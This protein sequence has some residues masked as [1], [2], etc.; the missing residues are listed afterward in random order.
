[1][2]EALLWKDLKTED[3]QVQC[4]LCSQYCRIKDREKGFCGVRENRGGKLYTL[5]ADRAAAINVDPVE[6]KPLY[7]FMPGTQTFSF[8][9]MGCNL[10]CEFCQN[11]TLSASAREGKPI[12]G[13]P[14]TPE[15][16]V[17]SAMAHNCL[18]VAYTY[19][20][21]TIFFELMQPTAAEAHDKG[22]KNFMVSNGFM[23]P[24]CLDELE[25][26][27]DAANIDLKAFTEEFYENI[28]GARL[29]PVLDNLRHIKRMGWWLEVTTLVIPGLND[30]PREL[31]EM[32]QFIHDDL[33]PEVPWHVSRFHPDY[34]MLDRPVTPLET[35]EK[36]WEIGSAAGLKYVYVG[37]M[38]GHD[39]DNT[40]CPKCGYVVI[41]RSGFRILRADPGGKCAKC[42]AQVAGMGMDTLR[43]TEKKD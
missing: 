28:C 35:L 26:L 5:V 7:H 40:R 37:N 8:G 10:R 33:G 19:S 11:Y 9:T 2:Q 14:V 17:Q 31:K 36:A 13:R 42:G 12:D 16:L 6:K 15:T 30:S 32:A 18:S 24:Q 25:Y 29:G 23:S 27:I 1:M 20:E 4:R 22:L 43:G 39:G 41:Q 34:Q 3:H 21:P 38:P